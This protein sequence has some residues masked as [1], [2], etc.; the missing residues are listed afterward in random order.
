MALY[1]AGDRPRGA[2]SRWS[3][4]HPLVPSGSSHTQ[5]TAVQ[6]LSGWSTNETHTQ[7]Y[8]RSFLVQKMTCLCGWGWGS[9]HLSVS[10][11]LTAFCEQGHRALGR[12]TRRTGGSAADT[13]V[14][15]ASACF[16]PPR[17]RLLPCPVPTPWSELEPGEGQKEKEGMSP[18]G[19]PGG[20]PASA[21]ASC[22]CVLRE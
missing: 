11:H 18:G 19:S 13:L 15:G 1:R 21:A 7:N 22:L 12:K 2:S 6:H 5:A 20:H 17:S 16:L 10:V 3:T 9:V 4:S 8:L 14:L